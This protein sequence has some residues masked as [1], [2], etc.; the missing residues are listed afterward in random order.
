MDRTGWTIIGTGVTLA[1]IVILSANGIHAS[2]DASRAEAAAD[3][4]AHQAAMDTFRQEAAADRKE[5]QQEMRIL[6]GRQARVEGA[7]PW[8]AG[9]VSSTPVPFWPEAESE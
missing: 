7:L 6:A 3:Q 2:I 1:G 4:R 5:F 9:A 8:I